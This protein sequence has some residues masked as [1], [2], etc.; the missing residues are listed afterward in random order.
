MASAKA[1]TASFATNAS[2]SNG[3]ARAPKRR[4]LSSAGGSTTTRC[5]RIRAL[6]TS[7]QTNLQLGKQKTHHLAMQRAR[8]LR[9]LGLRAPARCTTRPHRAHTANGRRLKLAVVRTI[10]AGH[11]D[12]LR[13]QRCSGRFHVRNLVPTTDLPRGDA[14]FKSILV[15]ATLGYPGDQAK[16]LVGVQIATDFLLLAI[17]LAH[18]VG[19]VRRGY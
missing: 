16:F 14:L 11:V 17:F 12:T 5:G 3:S 6:A 4:S 19:R 2:A 1:S 9:Y 13:V 18:L 8:A 7:R 15:F 10:W